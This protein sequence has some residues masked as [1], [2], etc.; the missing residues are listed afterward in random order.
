MGIHWA[1]AMGTMD[2]AHAA[3]HILQWVLVRYWGLC[4]FML[5]EDR[6]ILQKACEFIIE[7]LKKISYHN[8]DWTE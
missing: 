3:R 7:I 5:H 2:V 6:P 1:M 4:V 8:Y